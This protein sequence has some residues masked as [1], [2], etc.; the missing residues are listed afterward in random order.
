M[1]SLKKKP[2][3]NF[4]LQKQ[5]NSNIYV[6]KTCET[7]FGYCNQSSQEVQIVK[8]GKLKKTFFC[9]KV[10]TCAKIHG[11]RYNRP[12]VQSWIN[13]LK[14]PINRIRRFCTVEEPGKLAFSWFSRAIRSKKS[15]NF[16]Q[17]IEKRISIFFIKQSALLCDFVPIGNRT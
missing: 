11:L 4:T 8:V 1:H 13:Q 12:L 17:N 5:C 7:D 9:R 16:W 15:T 2:Q 10:T 6:L 14:N 3:H